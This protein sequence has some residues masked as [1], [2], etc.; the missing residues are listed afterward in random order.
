MVPGTDFCV[1]DFFRGFMILKTY[2]SL[3]R[4]KGARALGDPYGRT[5]KV[6]PSA[7]PFYMRRTDRFTAVHHVTGKVIE[8]DPK[9]MATIYRLKLARSRIV[10]TDLGFALEEEVDDDEF[11][12]VEDKVVESVEVANKDI[13]LI[14][15][16]RVYTIDRHIDLIFK[17]LDAIH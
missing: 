5:M 11:E 6:V 7:S 12:G 16:Q 8:V 10:R 13:D 4:K 3:L 15:E 2:A 1:E 9:T 17:G 14:N